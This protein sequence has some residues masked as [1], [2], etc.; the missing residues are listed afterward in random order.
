[1]EGM[2]KLAKIGLVHLSSF[3]LVCSTGFCAFIF[4]DVE[5]RNS[6]L[7]GQIQVEPRVEFGSLS[8]IEPRELDY[9]EYR[10]VFEQGGNGD[11]FD[12]T[13]GISLTPRLE[14]VFSDYAFEDGTTLSEQG[15]FVS[16]YLEFVCESEIFNE[17]GYAEFLETAS[18]QSYAT[19]IRLDVDETRPSTRFAF[20]PVFVWREG[21]KPSTSQAYADLLNR[22][23]AESP[24][25]VLILHL[26]A[27]KEELG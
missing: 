12:E 8:V 13:K 23:Y 19:R 20:E 4:S 15:Y 11:E 9:E 3:F 2:A 21:K 14:F 25:I 1:M 18:G 26:N 24:S 16:F 5:E 6:G 7:S 10:I 27:E 22:L 17:G